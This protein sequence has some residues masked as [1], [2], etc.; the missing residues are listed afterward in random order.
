VGSEKEIEDWKK[1]LDIN[2]SPETQKAV[3]EEMHY[4]LLGRLNAL[5]QK[6]ESSMGRPANF[7]L[8]RP[9]TAK[10]FADHGVDFRDVDPGYTTHGLPSQPQAA[11]A[12][13]PAAAPKIATRDQ[14]QAFAT[15][16]KMSFDEAKKAAEAKG[17]TVQ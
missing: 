13:A 17:Y 11:P 5:K 9:E 12:A 14:G 10:Q 6:Y 15:E 1:G 8:L 4:L 2:A 3:I 7:H 16:H